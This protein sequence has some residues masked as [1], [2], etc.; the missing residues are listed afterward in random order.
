MASRSLPQ[1][2]R[3]RQRM[4]HAPPSLVG[5]RNVETT[6]RLSGHHFRRGSRKIIQQTTKNSQVTIVL[7]AML[8]LGQMVGCKSGSP[9]TWPKPFATAND[10]G[11]SWKTAAVNSKVGLVSYQNDQESQSDNASA[12]LIEAETESGDLGQSAP[13]SMV[14]PA[15]PCT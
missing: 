10:T 4:D 2:G 1:T 6:Q 7:V 14:A 11:S 13:D 9:I 8:V 15:S 3:T 12:A 5:I